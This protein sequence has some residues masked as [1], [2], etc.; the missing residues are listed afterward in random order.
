MTDADR[1]QAMLDALHGLC[2]CD[3]ERILTEASDA[4][5]VQGNAVVVDE[6]FEKNRELAVFGFMQAATSA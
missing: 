3:A 1:M 4:V 2:V 6:D 5:R